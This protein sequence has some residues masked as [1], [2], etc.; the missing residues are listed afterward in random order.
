MEELFGPVSPVLIAGLA[1]AFIQ[2]LKN[3]FSVEGWRATALAGA[4]SF[5]LGAPYH[6]FYTLRDFEGVMDWIDIGIISYETFLYSLGLWALTIGIYG[7]AK[8]ISE[9]GK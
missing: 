8:K 7:T 5:V 3:A 4:V 6:L 9:N 2:L 1:M